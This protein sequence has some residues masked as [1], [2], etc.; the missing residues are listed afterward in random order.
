MFLLVLTVEASRQFQLFLGVGESPKSVTIGIGCATVRLSHQVIP[1]QHF[2]NDID[3]MKTTSVNMA[4][5]RLISNS[6]F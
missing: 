4:L 6:S 3:S 1:V 5:R 2:D